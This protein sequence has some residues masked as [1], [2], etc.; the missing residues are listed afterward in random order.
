MRTKVALVVLV[1]AAAPAAADDRVDLTTTLYQEKH[2]G[3]KGLTV[4]HPQLSIGA[5]I[6]DHVSLDVGYAADIVTG[7]TAAVYSPDAV[8]TATPFDDIRHEA[9]LSF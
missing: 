6:G 3:A 8:S 4:V 9:S 5:D 1:A 7:A 2:Q